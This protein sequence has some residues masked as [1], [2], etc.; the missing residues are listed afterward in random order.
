MEEVEVALDVT[1]EAV[2][3]NGT[4]KLT[5]R[6][7]ACGKIRRLVDVIIEEHGNYYQ[8]DVERTAWCRWCWPGKFE[9]TDD[10]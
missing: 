2:P 8:N 9:E 1:S 6:C 3:M 4:I 5:I 10:E 7:D